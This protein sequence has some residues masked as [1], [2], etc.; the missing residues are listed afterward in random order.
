VPKLRC[1]AKLV[2]SVLIVALVVLAITTFL[3]PREKEVHAQT[4]MW[5]TG[6][7]FRRAVTISNTNS[8]SIAK[9]QLRIFINTASLISAS[10]MRSDCGDLRVTDSDGATLLP[11]WIEPGTCNTASTAVWVNVTN[12]PASGTKTIFIYYGNSTQTSVANPSAVFIFF[13]NFSSDPN[14]NGKWVVYRY[15]GDASN[16]FVWDSTNRRVYLTKATSNLSVMAFFRGVTTPSSFRVVFYGGAGGGTGADGFAFAF[17]KDPSPYQKYGRACNDGSLGLMVLSSPPSVC[18]GSKGYAVEFDNY[19]NTG[20]P[21]ANHNAIVNTTSVGYPYTHIAYV[22]T[23]V[24]NEDNAVHMYEITFDGKTL[25][26]SI[27]GSKQLSYT[28]TRINAPGSA[29][30]FGAGTGGY[31]NNHWIERFVLLA[32]YVNPEPSTTVGSEEGAPPPALQSPPPGWRVDLQA[33]VTFAWVYNPRFSGD[34]QVGFRLQISNTTSFTILFY[35]TGQ[36]GSTST[37]VAITL[38]SNMTVGTYYWRVM[39]WSSDGPSEWSAP[40]TIIVDRI[41]V[42]LSVNTTRTDVGRKVN[43]SWTLKFQSDGSPITSFSITIA[44]NGTAVYSGSTSYFIDSYSSVSATV[45]TVSSVKDST[46]GVTAF[47]SN[48]VR[49]VW[50]TV[51]IKTFVP[52]KPR[53]TVGTVPSFSITAVYAYDGKAFQGTVYT[54]ATAVNTVGKYT[55]VVTGIKDNLYGLRTF[56]GNTTTSVIFDKLVVQSYRVKVNSASIAS[57]TRINVTM[58]IT[59]EATIVHAY[60]GLVLDNTNAV[61]VQLAGVSASW[62]GSNWIATIQPPGTIGSKTYT[63]VTYAESSLGVKLVDS[64]TFTVV[65]DSIAYSYSCNLISDSVTIR[66]S[67]ASDGKALP[68][69]KLC[70]AYAGSTSCASISNGVTTVQFTRTTNSTLV[71]ANATDGSFVSISPRAPLLYTSIVKNLV[72][73]AGTGYAS[74]LSTKVLPGLVY[75]KAELKGNASITTNTSLPVFLVKVNGAPSNYIAVSTATGTNVLLTN[76]GSTVEVV[77]ANSTTAVTNIGAGPGG[78][79]FLIGFAN[80]YNLTSARY[81]IGLLVNGSVAKPFAYINGSWRYG[82]SYSISFPMVPMLSFGYEGK[83]LS[84]YWVLAQARGYATGFSKGFWTSPITANYTRMY[85]FLMVLNQSAVA[86]RFGV[87]P[88]AFASYLAKNSISISVLGPYPAGLLVTT[89]AVTQPIQIVYSGSDIKVS[90]SQSPGLTL[91]GFKGF[92]LSISVGNIQLQNIE[93]NQ[94]PM[95]LYL[96]TGFTALLVVDTSAKTVSLTQ[97]ALPQPPGALTPAQTSV[98]ILAPPPTNAPLTQPAVAIQYTILVAVF[99]GVALAIWRRTGDFGYGT[100]VAGVASAIIGLVLGNGTA[101]AV[102][103][104]IMGI[105]IA[106]SIAERRT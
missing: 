24:G 64:P 3:L 89:I 52:A 93:V 77:Y 10:K 98:P 55:I 58:P 57:G 51:V 100:A 94:D 66:L 31:T 80:T 20:D 28:F 90:S 87:I 60:D 59:V 67:Y 17:F 76:L 18:Y 40:F 79:A 83:N 5:L 54:N 86:E 105:G 42:T 23:N 71:L 97:M 14:T 11:Y 26:L 25:T 9:Y 48:N 106:I 35:D 61:S 13:D 41:V 69:G 75:I 15:A 8:F 6:W 56:T 91:V 70:T 30:G 85:P 19:G 65:Y 29:M 32:Y 63:V 37:S 44:R 74:V 36:V 78:G 92:K 12:I 101:V 45:Y 7:R 81:M 39:V 95:T 62:G 47:T 43:V 96:P 33:T 68:S 53:T 2:A 38:P 72:Y 73:T 104:M 22:S 46:Y 49:V 82:T 50:D 102:A 84:V 1:S 88:S 34:S 27:D 4:A 99:T 21:S 103:L 16:E